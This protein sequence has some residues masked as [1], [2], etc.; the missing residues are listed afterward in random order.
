MDINY[1]KKTVIIFGN[2][3]KMDTLVNKCAQLSGEQVYHFFSN[4]GIL[5]PRRINCLAMISVLNDKI[6]MLHSNSL[7]RDYFVRLQYYRGFSEVQLFNLFSKICDSKDFKQYRINL[8]KLIILNFVG[9]NLSDGELNYLRN[10]K[11]TKMEKFEDYFTFISSGSLEQDNTFDGQDIDVLNEYLGYTASAQEIYD[12]AEKYG[13]ALPQRLKK[14]EM[15]DFIIYYMKE[16]GT[17]SETIED[18]LKPMSLT[19]L[20]N[21]A[22]ANGIPMQSNMNKQNLIT[23]LFYI[24]SQCEIQTTSVKRLEIPEEYVPLEFGVDLDVVNVFQNGEIKKVIYYEGHEKDEEQFWA[25]VAAE[26]GTDEDNAPIDRE[27]AVSENIPAEASKDNETDENT[28]SVAEEPVE[29]TEE[30]AADESAEETEEVATEEPALEAVKESAEEE[31]E[32]IE[33]AIEEPVEEEIEEIE[34]AVEEPAEEEIEEIEETIEEPVE[35]EIEEIEEVIEEPV[36]E[37]IEEIEEAIEE[38]VEE[39][40]EEIEETMEES[41]EEEIEEIEETIEEPAEEETEEYLMGAIDDLIRDNAIEEVEDSKAA[42]VSDD[43]SNNIKDVRVNDQFGS[44]KFLK[45][46]K[47]PGK[48]IALS[49]CAVIA[50]AIVIYCMVVLMK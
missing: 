42:E 1:E 39:E 7:N 27:E 4:R 45:Q 50:L 31:I 29:E 32:E 28:N 13:V 46:S 30:V 36:E 6:K 20:G 35:E 3:V 16:E 37:E 26:R 17:Y 11:K 5:L 25:N 14:N 24:L 8:F 23:Y 2:S 18:E 43:D 38:P 47:G 33:E 10:L 9:L 49:A 40:I 21:F 34:E 19:A 15:F 22:K 44:E 48:L 41:A 12:L